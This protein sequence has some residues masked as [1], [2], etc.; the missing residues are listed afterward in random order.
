MKAPKNILG[1]ILLT[2]LYLL[3]AC[4]FSR[5]LGIDTDR[6]LLVTILMVAAQIRWHM[7]DDSPLGK[8]SE[9]S[10]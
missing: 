3:T 8:T 9:H 2:A 1:T 10:K 7:R 5:V 4:A 6:A